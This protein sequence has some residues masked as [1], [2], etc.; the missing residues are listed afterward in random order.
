MKFRV[1]VK[2]RKYLWGAQ[3][4]SSDLI[5]DVPVLLSIRVD[6]FG[7]SVQI[8]SVANQN[9]NSDEDL[10]T[11]DAGGSITIPLNNRC[12]IFAVAASGEHCYLDC[13]IT[14]VP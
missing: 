13:E 8:G 11:L 4:T 14:S 9:S 2:N 1:R 5:T 12:G 3:K 6:E 7:G 10:G